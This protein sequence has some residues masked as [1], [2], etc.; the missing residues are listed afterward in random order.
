MLLQVFVLNQLHLFGYISPMVYLIFVYNYPTAQNRTA[1]LSIGFV[2]GI[3]LDIF[4]DSLAFNTLSLLII[5]YFRPYLLGFIFGIATEQKSFKFSDTALV[6]RMSYL[7]L[8][9][10][11][12]HSVFFIAE[13]MSISN[14]L[15]IAKKIITTS[16]VSFILMLLLLSLFSKQKK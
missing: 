15:L 13:G 14:G 8:L 9:V 3:I 11:I 7:G 4:T 2:F 10:L 5:T 16:I 6:Q 12:H 1:L